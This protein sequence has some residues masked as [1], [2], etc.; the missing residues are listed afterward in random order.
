MASSVKHA[1][2][3][4]SAQVWD[5]RQPPQ[6]LCPCGTGRDG[7]CRG[8]GTPVILPLQL[9][10]VCIRSLVACGQEP[11]C[12]G[13]HRAGENWFMSTCN[14]L[15]SPVPHLAYHWRQEPVGQK[16]FRIR[17]IRAPCRE[18]PGRRAISDLR[19]L[20]AQILHPA[21]PEH[22]LLRPQAP[23]QAP[24]LW[25]MEGRGVGGSLL[26][27]AS[28]LPVQTHRAPLAFCLCAL[29]LPQATATHRNP[30]T[31]ACR[32]T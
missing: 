29:S 6:T 7:V 15:L 1:E 2:V 20:H 5:H 17:W 13:L 14:D 27:C 30:R 3:E 22:A 11:L 23:P 26:N 31:P 25:C 21:T 9:Q 4:A 28:D 12:C 24:P 32:S 18:C 10:A 16:R 19:R 8:L